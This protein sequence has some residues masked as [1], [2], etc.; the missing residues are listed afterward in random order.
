MVLVID[1]SIDAMGSIDWKDAGYCIATLWE[2]A[3]GG[4]NYFDPEDPVSSVDFIGSSQEY[5]YKF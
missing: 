3:S 5:E 4:P 2:K 1:A